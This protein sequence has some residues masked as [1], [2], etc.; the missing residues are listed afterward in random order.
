[1]NIENVI[2]ELTTIKGRLARLLDDQG[3]RAIDSALSSLETQRVALPRKGKASSGKKRKVTPPWRL[4]IPPDSP[5]SFRETAK[6]T[7]LKHQVHLDIAC[8]LTEPHKGKPLGSHNIAVRMW[9][10]DEGLWYRSELDSEALGQRIREGTQ[11]RVMVRFHFDFANPEQQGPGFH[12]QLGGKQHG[13]EAC[14]H[15]ETLDVPR[16]AHHPMNLLMVCEFVAR[17]FYVDDYQ[18][19]AKDPTWK[20]ALTIAQRTYL[21]PF[22][23]QCSA[24]QN[25]TEHMFKPEESYLNRLWNR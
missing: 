18:E 16:F 23:V 1:M 12:L 7:R 9:S 2:Q 22:F 25:L 15:P 11:R 20:G 24:F 17:T 5:L 8:D 21:A 14:W 10:R 6:N 13:E 4:I 19:I 3:R